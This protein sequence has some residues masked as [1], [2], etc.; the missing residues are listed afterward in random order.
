MNQQN[1]YQQLFQAS[2]VDPMAAEQAAA[3]ASKQKTDSSYTLSNADR[4]I[5]QAAYQQMFQRQLQEAQ[6]QKEEEEKRIDNDVRQ[7][8]LLL[9]QAQETQV[10]ELINQ[11]AAVKQRLISERHISE[12]EFDR[13][14][15]SQDS[16][17]W[18]ERYDE[19]EE[20]DQL[21]EARWRQ[22]TQGLGIPGNPQRNEPPLADDT[23]QLRERQIELEQDREQSN[24]RQRRNRDLEL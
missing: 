4:N 15:R 10:T 2:G 18:A 16:A 9:D 24:R 21:F 7:Y 14:V 6:R 22:E 19:N 3:I 17:L 12:S 13:R 20:D 8:V 23:R 1:H 5:V 11:A